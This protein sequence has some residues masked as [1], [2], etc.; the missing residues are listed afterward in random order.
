MADSYMEQ[1]LPLKTSPELLDEYIFF[2]GRI[3]LGKIL[4]GTFELLFFWSQRCISL[5]TVEI[6]FGCT[7]R[8]YCIQARG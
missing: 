6:R 8:C 3:R 5:L 2:D 7:G 1:Y 4:E